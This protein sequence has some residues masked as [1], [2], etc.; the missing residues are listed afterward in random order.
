MSVCRAG[1]ATL[2]STISNERAVG[3]KRRLRWWKQLRG[4][5]YSLIR[6]SLRTRS[7]VP[8]QEE[9]KKVKSQLGFLSVETCPA[10][11]VAASKRYIKVRGAPPSLS[12]VT[13]H[14]H[15]ATILMSHMTTRSEITSSFPLRNS[16]ERTH[17]FNW[18][19][20][21]TEPE[22]GLWTEESWVH[23]TELPNRHN[24]GLVFTLAAAQDKVQGVKK[25][26]CQQTGVL[27]NESLCAEGGGRGSH[28]VCA[29]I[30]KMQYLLWLTLSK[31]RLQ[32][33]MTSSPE[34]PHKVSHCFILR[35]KDVCVS[36]IGFLYIV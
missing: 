8:S 17:G 7:T 14:C 35:L 11:G 5:S 25:R 15:V 1:S 24:T 6:R 28:Q 18:A 30:C 36:F 22:T 19:E 12:P 3:G 20:G 2:N 16:R 29:T 33:Q 13:Q 23:S 27:C 26:C 9:K 34:T 4:R 21:S 32:T 10:E 31:L